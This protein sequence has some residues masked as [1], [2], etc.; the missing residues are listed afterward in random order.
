M[1]IPYI[2]ME[3]R[4]MAIQEKLQG[5]FQPLGELVL[6]VFRPGKAGSGIILVS[7]ARWAWEILESGNMA[8]A[9]VMSC[10]GPLSLSKKQTFD[11]TS[12]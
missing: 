8:C 1:L 2:I 9:Q 6:V 7:G 10:S 11:S 5:I 12:L 3:H 4:T